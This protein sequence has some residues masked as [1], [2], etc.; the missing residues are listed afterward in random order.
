V[1]HN[2]TRKN[3]T[4]NAKIAVLFAIIMAIAVS[5]IWAHKNFQFSHIS[6]GAYLRGL[7]PLYVLVTIGAVI[8]IGVMSLVAFLAYRFTKPISHSAK[9]LLMFGAIGILFVSAGVAFTNYLFLKGASWITISTAAIGLFAA[10]ILLPAGFM[11][12]SR[13]EIADMQK[14]LEG[15]LT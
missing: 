4:N 7:A 11:V 6:W 9:C 14:L 12:Q 15:G 3:N 1:S 2:S 5:T 10:V 8:L 13:E